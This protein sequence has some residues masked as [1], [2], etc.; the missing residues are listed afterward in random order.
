M[1]ISKVWEK[2]KKCRTLHCKNVCSKYKTFRTSFY[3]EMPCRY[4]PFILYLFVMPV[5]NSFETQSNF[6]GHSIW[7]LNKKRSWLHFE[8]TVRQSQK[9]NNWL[10]KS[11]LLCLS[12]TL[13]FERKCNLIKDI[14]F[15]PSVFWC[16]TKFQDYAVWIL[17]FHKKTKLS[18][19]EGSIT[20]KKIIEY[21]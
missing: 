9:F 3:C 8:R 4:L 16:V 5:G 7:K 15:H 6:L 20:W 11:N 18:F 13:Y 19:N 21:I 17:T 2:P 12:T 1:E 14:E 10:R